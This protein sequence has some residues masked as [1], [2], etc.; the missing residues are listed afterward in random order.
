MSRSESSDLENEAAPTT[1]RKKLFTKNIKGK[2]RAKQLEVSQSSSQNSQ[3]GDEGAAA[4]AN[5]LEEIGN[6]AAFGYDHQSIESINSGD[7]YDNAGLNSVIQKNTSQNE[8]VKLIPITEANNIAAKLTEFRDGGQTHLVMPIHLPDNNHFVGLYIRL[9]PDESDYETT[10][11][12]PL[13]S[14]NSTGVPQAIAVNLNAILGIEEDGIILTSNI[15]QHYNEQVI[16]NVHCGAFT[17]FILSELSLGRIRVHNS[18]LQIQTGDEELTWQDIPD[19]KKTQSDNLGKSIRKRD[20]ELLSRRPITQNPLQILRSIVQNPQLDAPFEDDVNDMTA[21]FDKLLKETPKEKKYK[22]KLLISKAPDLMSDS[23]ED[24]LDDITADID[25]LAKK[26]ARARSNEPESL[27]DTSPDSSDSKFGAKTLMRK[28]STYT[29]EIPHKEY[30][31]NNVRRPEVSIQEIQNNPGKYYIANFRGDYLGYFRNSRIRREFVRNAVESTVDGKSTSYKSIALSSIRKKHPDDKEKRKE[32]V[33]KLDTPKKLLDPSFIKTYKSPAHFTSAVKAISPEHG[34][35]A[36]STS[37]DTKVTP[38]YSDHPKKGDSPLHPKYGD[39]TDKKP[40]HRLIGG[41]TVFVHEASKYI[42][43]GKADIEKLR[44]D[45]KI[46]GKSAIELDNEEIIFADKVSAKNVAGYVPLAYPNLSK[47]YNKTDKELFGMS[48]KTPRTTQPKKKTDPKTLGL[49]GKSDCLYPLHSNLQWKLAEKHMRQENPDGELLWVDKE[50]KFRRF[51][52][53]EIKKDQDQKKPII[54]IK[55][56]LR[57]SAK[58]PSVD[59]FDGPS[60]ESSNSS[61][62]KKPSSNPSDPESSM[63]KGHEK[64]RP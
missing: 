23:S 58:K 33:N 47:S 57:V 63:K 61:S 29:S 59:L 5:N 55:A 17:G 32:E 48:Q 44:T 22:P 28:I 43:K 49:G 20:V 25:Q 52:E 12:D 11:I 24:E 30:K 15:I 7:Y 26:V 13:G 36:I 60:L 35:P 27:S 16:S 18:R 31:I 3:A 34:N 38:K 9:L 6:I 42:Q 37:K 46:G 62:S 8:D 50:G 14:L 39:K 53:A 19:L 41:S 64:G 45:K 54:K 21:K 56:K 40:K 10:Y 4:P 2:V 51:T 1:V